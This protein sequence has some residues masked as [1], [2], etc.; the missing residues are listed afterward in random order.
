MGLLGWGHP[1]LMSVCLC[2]IISH[3]VTKRATSSASAADAIKKIDDLGYGENSTVKAWKRIIL[4]EV[5]VSPG[6][7]AG[8]S[9]VEEPSISMGTQNHVTGL[10]YYAVQRVGSNIVEEEMASL[11]SGNCSI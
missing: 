1:M 8:V 7:T 10:I 11:F 3:A 9:F 4:G 2:R 5:D 6:P